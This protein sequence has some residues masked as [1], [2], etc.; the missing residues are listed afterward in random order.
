MEHEEAGHPNHKA[1]R[2]ASKDAIFMW[3]YFF[4][5]FL[6]HPYLQVARPGGPREAHHYKTY[7]AGRN[8]A[9]F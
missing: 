8:A 1:A 7:Y 3:G 4:R 2:H 9:N 5:W 6:N